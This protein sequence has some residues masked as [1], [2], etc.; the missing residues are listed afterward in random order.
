MRGPYLLLEKLGEGGNGTVYKARHQAMKRVVALKVVRKELLG[1]AEV[2]GRFYR[3]IEVLSQISHPNI[4]HAYDAGPIG[5]D[6]VLAMEF[7]DGI[8][9]DRLVKE[10]GRLPAAQACEYIRQ[11]AVGLQHAHERGLIH[12]DIKP[13]NLLVSGVVSGGVVSGD[14]TTD[15]LHTTHHSPLTIHPSPLTRSRF[16]TWAWPGC[17]SRQRGARPAT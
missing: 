17:S 4:V 15:S 6:L 13:S 1:D 14:K 12:R 3:E 2:V 16:S 5:G 7:V 9:L 10:S 8:D 11:A